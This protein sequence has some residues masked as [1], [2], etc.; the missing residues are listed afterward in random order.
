M[1]EATK[2]LLKELQQKKAALQDEFWFNQSLDMN[3]Y[4]LNTTP[5]GDYCW[6]DSE[7]EQYGDEEIYIE[8]AM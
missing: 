1:N 5:T 3:E 4:P 2:K 7:C 6:L 8:E